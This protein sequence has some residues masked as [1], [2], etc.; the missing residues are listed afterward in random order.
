MQALVQNHICGNYRQFSSNYAQLQD[1]YRQ[2]TQLHLTNM[3]ES[4]KSG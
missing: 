3:V 2:L 4:L 1:K